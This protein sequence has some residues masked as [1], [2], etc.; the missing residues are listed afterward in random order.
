MG[1]D[2]NTRLQLFLARVTRSRKMSTSGGPVRLM[3]TIHYTAA[4][5]QMENYLTMNYLFKEEIY[6]SFIM[7]C[8]D[9]NPVLR[10]YEASTLP[11]S[12]APSPRNI[13]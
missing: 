5:L 1:T 2:R 4:S 13:F 11:T 8:L 12:E 6:F 10:A 3:E 9:T 7:P